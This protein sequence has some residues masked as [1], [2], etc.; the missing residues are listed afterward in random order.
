[1]HGDYT[2]MLYIGIGFFILNLIFYL[3]NRKDIK[4]GL[5]IKID[6]RG[7]FYNQIAEQTFAF[8]GYIIH[9]LIFLVSLSLIL[10]SLYVIIWS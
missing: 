10:I 1:M 2:I 3:Y 6:P 8:S 5:K 9:W 4:N 7:D